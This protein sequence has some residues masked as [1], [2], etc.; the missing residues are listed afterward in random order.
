LLRIGTCDVS[1]LLVVSGL[2]FEQI[3]RGRLW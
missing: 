1:R 3:C 2:S